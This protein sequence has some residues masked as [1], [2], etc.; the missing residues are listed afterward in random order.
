MPTTMMMGTV[1]M[2]P[3]HWC[4]RKFVVVVSFARDGLEGLMVFK[5]EEKCLKST[6][7]FYRV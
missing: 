6:L 7:Q 5:L 1:S 2:K 4:Y 3:L